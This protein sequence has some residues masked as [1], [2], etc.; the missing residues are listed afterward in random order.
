MKKRVFFSFGIIFFVAAALGISFAQEYKAEDIRI[1]AAEFKDV[2][3]IKIGQA[4]LKQMFSFGGRYDSNVFLT[5]SD[6]KEDY[7]NVLNPAF[8]LDLPFGLGGRH[9]IQVLYNAEIGLYSDYRK[10]DYVNQDVGV[11]FDFKLPFGYLNARNIFSRTSDRSGTEFT[12][13][14]KRKENQSDVA[15]GVEINRLAYELAYE[16]FIESY[17]DP[18]YDNLGYQEDVYTLTGYYQAFPKTQALLEYKYGV[19][20][21]PDD[22]TRNG[23]YNQLR[24]GLKGQLTGKTVGIVKAG[25]QAREYDIAGRS[26]YNGFVAEAGITTKF[27][28]RTELTTKFIRVAEESIYAP[29]NYYDNNSL[30]FDLTQQIYSRLKLIASLQAECHLYPEVTP[31][32]NKKRR[33]TILTS[34]LTL[35]YAIKDWWKAKLGYE[36]KKDNS[37]IGTSDYKR[38]LVSF[39]FTILM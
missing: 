19:V 20:D 22:N 10:Q 1:G 24:L 2:K 31:V 32:V 36:Y 14:V 23:K 16:H 35:E 27:S 25:Y 8:L 3:G 12:S 29:N 30:S 39:M 9:L 15:L 11:N 4:Q 34:S 5:P 28:E 18:I 38:N 6:E 21:Y 7:I 37:N 26:G 13:Q 17:L 33:D